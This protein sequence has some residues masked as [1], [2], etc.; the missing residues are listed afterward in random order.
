MLYRFCKG[1]CDS[2]SEDVTLLNIMTTE[3]RYYHTARIIMDLGLK[4][5]KAITLTEKIVQITEV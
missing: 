1:S 2:I 5:E 3:F 4:P